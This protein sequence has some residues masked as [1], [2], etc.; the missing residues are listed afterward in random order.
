MADGATSAGVAGYIGVT[1]GP[2]DVVPNWNESATSVK[3]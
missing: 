1:T 2:D 3:K